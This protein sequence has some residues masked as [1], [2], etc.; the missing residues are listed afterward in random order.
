MGQADCI[1]VG[2]DFAANQ[3]FFT[4][5]GGLVG[6]V[7][8][9]ETEDASDDF[10]VAFALHRPGDSALLNCGAGRFIFDLETFASQAPPTATVDLSA[11]FS[12]ADRRRGGWDSESDSA[13]EEE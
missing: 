7:K 3:A 13:G 11:G 9:G 6:A 10:Y 5:N 4:R 2:V 1:G 8:L 12:T